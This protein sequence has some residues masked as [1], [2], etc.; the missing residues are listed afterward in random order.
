[1]SLSWK[2]KDKPLC[3]AFD[4]KNKKEELVGSGN[5]QMLKK[6]TEELDV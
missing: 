5:Y 1:M 3:T 2:S 6:I 4:Q